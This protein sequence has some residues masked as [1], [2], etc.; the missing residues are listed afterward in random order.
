MKLNKTFYYILLS[1]LLAGSLGS[2]D[3]DGEMITTGGAPATDIASSS[4]VI[5]LSVEHRD[6]LALSLYWDENGQITLSDPRVEAPDNVVSNTL[7]FATEE[8]FAAPYEFAAE[9]G[10]YYVQMSHQQ[11]NTACSRLG[12]PALVP[13]TVYVR[14]KSAVGVNVPARYSNI[15]EYTITPYFIDWSVAKVLDSSHADTGIILASPEENRIYS[16]FVGAAAWENWF[17]L[18]SDFTEWGNLGEDGK[19]FHASSADSKWNFWYPA[20]AG[21]YFTTVNT[22]EGWWS[23]LWIE[24]LEISGD[25]SGSMSY[26]RAAN[27][28]TL[29]VSSPEARSVSISIAGTSQLYDRTTT[30]DGPAVAAT[31]GFG[32][33]AEALTFGESA[34]AVSINLPAGDTNI[35]LDL[36]NP[37]L[38]TV[39]CGEAAEV[40]SIS[41]LLYFSGLVNWDGFD[42][43]LVLTDADAL[44]YGGA[45]YINS[46]WGYRAYS[47]A[48]WS[49]A[50]KGADDATPLAGNLV[51]A[52]SEGNIPAPAEGLYTMNFDMKNLSYSL[53]AISSLS[54][55]GA[56]DDWSLSP[57]T[58]SADNPEVWTLE[59]AKT[60]ETPWGCKII[61]NDDWN[62]FFGGGE[63][64]GT[65]YLRT[66][67][68]ASGFTGDNAVEIGK[69]AVLTVDLGN[70]TY[71]FTSK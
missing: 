71:S 57:M 3:K 66:D 16:G 64:E 40:P 61:V 17:L 23:A 56:N 33:S 49:A 20:P 37:K 7:Q 11:L 12:L 55:T 39:G 19:S 59:F 30:A 46:E 8:T 54:F 28:W 1:T 32:G 36:S 21:C 25:I 47:E 60:A 4:S 35:V 15:I 58:Q 24:S 68:G 2:C 9:Q 18:E 34:S 14:L 45:H 41:P 52:D 6:D 44:T 69:T 13:A 31:V 29:A 53:T 62:L 5:V 70:Q 50:F 51:A 42:D 63:Q 38:W 65:L 48:D 22:A 67:S 43:T 10:K 26:N 27:Q